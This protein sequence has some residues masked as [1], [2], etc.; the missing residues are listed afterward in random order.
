ML[1]NPYHVEIK[2]KTP[3][4]RKAELGKKKHQE[5]CRKNRAKRKKSKK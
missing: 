5:T 4:E 1:F 3:E 2:Y